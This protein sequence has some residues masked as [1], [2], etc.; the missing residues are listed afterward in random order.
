MLLGDLSYLLYHNVL[1]SLREVKSL[2]I[3]FFKL[4][5]MKHTGPPGA[6]KSDIIFFKCLFFLRE[7]HEGRHAAVRLTDTEWRGVESVVRGWEGS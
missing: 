6:G 2:R 1:S 7:E 3:V 4:L 5:Q